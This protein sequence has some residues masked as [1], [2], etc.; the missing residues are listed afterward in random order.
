M[1]KYQLIRPMNS[2][3]EEIPFKWRSKAHWRR[4][5]AA[6]CKPMYMDS[7]SAYSFI[8]FKYPNVL[9]AINYIR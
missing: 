3:L 7:I 6:D 4:G 1:Q 8:I 9:F 5:Y 2:E